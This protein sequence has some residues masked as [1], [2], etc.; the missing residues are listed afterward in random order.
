LVP[1]RCTAF[2]FALTFLIRLIGQTGR[3]S[4]E[5]SSFALGSLKGIEAKKALRRDENG[6]GQAS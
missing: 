3:I 6:E 5:D 1:C 4:P 2:F